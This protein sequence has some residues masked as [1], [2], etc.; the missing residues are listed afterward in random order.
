MI[1]FFTQALSESM[2]ATAFAKILS[3]AQKHFKF[4]CSN[5]WKCLQT[6]EDKVSDLLTQKIDAADKENDGDKTKTPA[7]GPS[8]VQAA[9]D[10]VDK[11][12]RAKRSRRARKAEKEKATPE[13]TTQTPPEAAPALPKV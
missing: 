9:L 2:P 6:L 10:E 11:K 1:A 5:D 7:P 4:S 3:A 12:V 13:E 8:G